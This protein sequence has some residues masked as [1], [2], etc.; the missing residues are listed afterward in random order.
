M[1]EINETWILLVFQGSFDLSVAL[2]EEHDALLF[3]TVVVIQFHLRVLALHLL[4][5]I[6]VGV[7]S[8]C[9]HHFFV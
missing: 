8:I 3:T 2:S 5:V 4:F 7:C 1:E 9:P 6:G